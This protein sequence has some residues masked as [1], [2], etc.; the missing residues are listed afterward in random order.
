MTLI[1]QHYGVVTLDVH[2][3]EGCHLDVLFAVVETVDY[4]PL[5]Q[6]LIGRYLILHI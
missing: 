1:L 4:Q 3:L 2:V 6:K 5:K